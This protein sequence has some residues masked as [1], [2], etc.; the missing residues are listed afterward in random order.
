MNINTNTPI[1]VETLRISL[2]QLTAKDLLLLKE[3][4]E[5]RLQKNNVDWLDTE[6][7][8]E[9]REEANENISLDSLRVALAK[10]RGPMSDVIISERED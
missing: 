8:E 6:Y 7:M 2:D 10:I 1:S 3:E 5:V 9:A 4:I